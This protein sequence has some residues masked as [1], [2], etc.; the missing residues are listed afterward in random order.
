M[1]S[2]PKE[3]FTDGLERIIVVPHGIVHWIYASVP[4]AVDAKR[5]LIR[6]A[7][8]IFRVIWTMNWVLPSDVV[9]RRNPIIRYIH[10]P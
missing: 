4:L 10:I 2:C 3:G 8:M 6:V 7:K 5:Q 9:L 1:E